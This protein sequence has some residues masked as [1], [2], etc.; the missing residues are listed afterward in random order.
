MARNQQNTSIGGYAARVALAAGV[1]AVMLL[2]PELIARGLGLGMEVGRSL[3]PSLESCLQRSTSLGY[4]H[5]P[6]CTGGGY[7]GKITSNSLGF[8]SAEIRNDGS[9]RV[10]AI[11]DSCTFG[12][13]VEQ[14]EA[15]PAILET[16]LNDSQLHTHY[17]VINAGHSGYTAYQGAVLLEEKG[18]ALE[19]DIVTIAFGFNALT[20]LGDTEERLKAEA[21]WIVLLRMDDFFINQSKL[22]AWV[23]WQTRPEPSNDAELSESPA[24][25]N[26]N[27]RRMVAAAREGGAKVVLISFWHP[28]DRSR[29]PHEIAEVSRDLDVPLI[30]YRGPR[31]D[32]VH[33]TTRGHRILA[34][35]IFRTLR[36]N[37]WLN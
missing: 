34:K 29:F 9:R 27:L 11:G 8:R 23:R 14:H 24:R 1:F 13:K 4:E 16:L 30:T 31:M 18:L 22:Y 17:Q 15:Y 26:A 12:W 7:F 10:L 5:I 32:V 6:N 20:R 21:N 35:K 28:K 36:D 37:Q 3:R 19:P 25:Y 33:P 2:T